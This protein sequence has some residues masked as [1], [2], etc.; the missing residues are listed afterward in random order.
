MSRSTEAGARGE[1][2]QVKGD[3][4][5]AIEFLL[6]A[7]DG[8]EAFALAQENTRWRTTRTRSGRRDAG[9]VPP[10]RG[11][12][13]VERGSREGGGRA[14]Q[15]RRARRR[16]S[17]VLKV[18][19]ACVDRAI[20][21]AG[22]ARTTPSPPSSWITSPGRRTARRRTTRICSSCTSRC[23]ITTPPLAPPCSSRSRSRRWATTRSR[24][25]SCSRR[26][27]N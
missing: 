15:A 18:G 5:G 1:L 2:L 20:D 12:F 11:V 8:A 19:G 7:R 6:L 3:V 21:V 24:T 22:E 14:R 23:G 17:R 4:R 27:R 10:A 16:R 13:R 25:R 26:T 9:G